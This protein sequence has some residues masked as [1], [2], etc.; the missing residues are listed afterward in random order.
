MLSRVLLGSWTATTGPNQ[1]F[2]G[3]WS[4]QVLLHNANRAFGSWTLLN[5]AGEVVLEGTWSV[6]KTGQR[7]Q[8]TWTARTRDV[9]AKLLGQPRGSAH[10]LPT[11]QGFV[12]D[13]NFADNSNHRSSSRA[14]NLKSIGLET[15]AL[16]PA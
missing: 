11:I 10:D 1:I 14:S 6:Q 7:W 13:D 4:A 5:D 2:R 12:L 8:G 9:L 15:H 3:A 16:Q